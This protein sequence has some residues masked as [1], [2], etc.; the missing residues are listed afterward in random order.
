MEY[1][2]VH[3]GVTEVLQSQHT[4]VLN[5]TT[6]IEIGRTLLSHATIQHTAA[7]KQLILSS[8]QSGDTVLI[9]QN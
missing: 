2:S 4:R 9:R 3:V 6:L 5:V 8:H 1:L 7:N